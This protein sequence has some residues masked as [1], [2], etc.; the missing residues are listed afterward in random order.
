MGWEEWCD[1]APGHAGPVLAQKG[2]WGVLAPADETALGDR[3]AALGIGD[4]RPIVVYADGPRSRG[5]EG[6]I[7]WM[8]SYFGAA[9]VRL[10]DGGWSAWVEAG[11]AVETGDAAPVPGSFT[12]RLQPE[13][14][15]TLE[16]L[17]RTMRAGAAPR[18]IDTRSPAEYAG[19]IHA[20]L[21]RRGHLPGAQLVPFTDLFEADGRYIQRDRYLAMPLPSVQDKTAL[22]AYCEVGV[23]A[24]LFAMLHEAYTGQVV[25]VY[26]GS[27][28]EWALHPELPLE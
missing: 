26:D 12:V 8:L 14:R 21:P 6:R 15:R 11:G 22:V 23:R 20:Y 17:Y 13:R 24:S 10:L 9:D 4:G 3:L 18:L 1:A 27:L 16:N 7:A 25:A 2:Y 19:Q 5:R 28:M